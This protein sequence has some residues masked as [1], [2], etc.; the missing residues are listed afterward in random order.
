V[1]ITFLD[2]LHGW[3]SVN[4]RTG[5]L[6][7]PGVMFATGD[8]GATWTQATLPFSGS[9]YFENASVGWLVGSRVPTT[10]NLIA[11]TLDGGITWQTQTLAGPTN[12]QGG[13]ATIGDPVMYTTDDGS[14][15][16]TYGTQL[17]IYSTRDSG[18]TWNAGSSFT[19]P[20]ED[21][22]SEPTA[23][24]AGLTGYVAVGTTIYKTSDA[25][26]TWS[27][28]SAAQFAGAPGGLRFSSTLS[29]W[30]FGFGGTCTG[31]KGSQT[32]SY[33]WQA[34]HTSNG[35]LTWVTTLDKTASR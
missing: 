13:P 16:V 5:N 21:N 25:G 4:L 26:Q 7:N 27:A 17:E 15:P 11:M 8:G 34:Q 28:L 14:L 23:T 2:A 22:L 24:S 19:L 30:A 29:G 18:K 6:S 32:C 9:L 33:T 1:S 20:G 31:P 3:V 12:A 10:R 35:G